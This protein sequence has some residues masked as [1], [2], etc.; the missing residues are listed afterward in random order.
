MNAKLGLVY[1]RLR[2]TLKKKRCLLF[3]SNSIVLLQHHSIDANTLFTPY[4]ASKIS[5]SENVF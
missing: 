3:T 4:K 5:A 1:L 2:W